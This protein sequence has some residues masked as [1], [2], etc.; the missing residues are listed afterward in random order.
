[1][2]VKLWLD[3]PS[4]FE[5][6]LKHHLLQ[7]GS[8]SGAEGWSKHGGLP[9]DPDK[10]DDSMFS[11]EGNLRLIEL[12]MGAPELTLSQKR[13]HRPP[14]PFSAP[15]SVLSLELFGP[16]SCMP[17]RAAENSRFW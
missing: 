4:A 13:Q 1:M 2:L 12:L 16:S 17:P 8:G 3:E 6:Y 7:A 15:C 11:Q 10:G 14:S 5:N 9:L